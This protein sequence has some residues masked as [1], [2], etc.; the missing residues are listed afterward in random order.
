MR[1]E[2]CLLNNII[3]PLHFTVNPLIEIS[4]IQFEMFCRFLK[5]I[6]SAR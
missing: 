1:S 4:E 2:L 5:V 6:K 3:K